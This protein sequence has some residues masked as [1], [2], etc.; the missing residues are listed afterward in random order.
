MPQPI[1]RT[2][3]GKSH[4]RMT[5]PTMLLLMGTHSVR[6]QQINSQILG[7]SRQLKGGY[8]FV[9]PKYR[10]ELENAIKKDREKVEGTNQ[11]QEDGVQ[12]QCWSRSQS[13]SNFP[14]ISTGHSRLETTEADMP[15]KNYP[16][17]PEPSAL[18]A[19]P[20]V[21]WNKPYRY[22]RLYDDSYATYLSGA[23]SGL[24]E[25]QYYAKP[26]PAIV[27]RHG[28]PCT[29]SYYSHAWEGSKALRP[30]VSYVDQEKDSCRDGKQ[31]DDWSKSRN[32]H[33]DWYRTDDPRP[34][35]RLHGEQYY[36]NQRASTPQPTFSPKES[37]EL[38][39]P[40]DDSGE[41]RTPQPDSRRDIAPTAQRPT[42]PS[43]RIAAAKGCPRLHKESKEKLIA[44]LI[45]HRDHP[46]PDAAEKRELA[47]EA[48]LKIRQVC[49]MII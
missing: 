41:A 17:M 25:Q 48:R 33:D 40:S 43:P 32:R 13:R 20:V 26:A 6:H 23:N 18:L 12:K 37:R 42:P 1:S 3:I 21:Y 24:H 14:L 22:G 7:G 27:R 5:H 34:N 49:D 15:R 45:L 44:W 28:H 11:G 19:P 2:Q 31:S 35:P 29:G 30:P 16:R 39:L 38:V 36:S 47:T 8:W 46:Y 9:R 10:M 4:F